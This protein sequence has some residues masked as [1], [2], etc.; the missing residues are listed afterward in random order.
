MATPKL[1]DQLIPTKELAGMFDIPYQTL[2][3]NI[4]SGKINSFQPSGKGGKQFVYLPEMKK[5]MQTYRPH[6]RPESSPSLFSSDNNTNKE[7][8]KQAAELM[9]QGN[10][11]FEKAYNL[12]KEIN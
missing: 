5:F 4:A 10:L 1:V 11:L 7:I 12:L 3:A 8:A 9:L 6:R 2:M